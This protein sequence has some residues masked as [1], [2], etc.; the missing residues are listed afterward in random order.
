VLVV[1]CANK[2]SRSALYSVLRTLQ[3]LRS[4]VVG[5]TMNQVQGNQNAGFYSYQ[6]RP[7]RATQPVSV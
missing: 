1:A 3:R 5:I 6:Y 4:N 2:T 7:N